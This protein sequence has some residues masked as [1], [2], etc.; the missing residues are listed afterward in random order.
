[1]FK[2]VISARNGK[3]SI[4]AG[5]Q[6][7]LSTGCKGGYAKGCEVRPGAWQVMLPGWAPLAG[8]RVRNESGTAI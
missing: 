3:S 8:L 5:M 2:R 1:M 7:V 4:G 6:R